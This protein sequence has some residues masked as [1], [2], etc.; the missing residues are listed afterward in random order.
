MIIKPVY[1][2]K[3]KAIFAVTKSRKG[4]MAQVA[5]EYYEC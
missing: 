4:I 2:M 5:F 1:P 3:F